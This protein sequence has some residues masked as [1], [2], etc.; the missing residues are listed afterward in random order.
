MVSRDT[1]SL[2]RYVPEVHLRILGER[3]KLESF[4]SGARGR[5][6]VEWLCG[7][8]ESLERLFRY[9][10][11][12][13]QLRQVVA[14]SIADERDFQRYLTKVG[15]N[16]VLEDADKITNLA[17]VAAYII[18]GLYGDARANGRKGAHGA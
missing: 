2:V 9:P 8:E 13:H 14:A 1:P 18:V 16:Q 17:K 5:E 10:P 7:E 4:F 15:G 11:T 12:P 3:W 6:Y